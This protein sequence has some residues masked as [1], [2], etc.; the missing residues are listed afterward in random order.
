MGNVERADAVLPRVGRLLALDPL[1]LALGR[2]WHYAGVVLAC[3]ML[4][5]TVSAGMRNSFGVFVSPLVEQFG[6]SLGAVSFAYFILFVSGVPLA[7]LAGWLADTFGVRPVAIVAVVLFV[8][9]LLLTALMTELWQFYV[10][11]A[12]LTGGTGVI[13]TTLLPVTMTQWFHRRAGTAV[14]LTF[15][16]AGLG[17]FVLAVLFGWLISTLGW[18]RA[19]LILGVVT[20]VPMLAAALLLR[21]HPAQLGLSAYGQGASA[22]TGPVARRPAPP[23]GLSQVRRD[24]TIW[25]L[26]AMHFLGCVAHAVPLAHVVRLAVLKGVPDVLAAGL[27]STVSVVSIVSRFGVPILIERWSAKTILTLGYALQSLAVL[28]YLWADSTLALYLISIA[29]GLAFGAEMSSFP[30][31]NRRYYGA[32]APLNSIHAWEMVGALVGM[33]LGGWLGGVLFDWTGSYTL[34]IALAALLGLVAVPCILALP[35]QSDGPVFA[36]PEPGGR[37]LVDAHH[38]HY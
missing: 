10:F 13:F 11:Y 14:G 35:R 5:V 17:P 18:T 34:S 27:L 19:F 6:W 4:I 25:L 20:G 28:S 1:A 31:L 3:A 29:F 24:R 16:A 8:A 32:R 12:V 37:A 7:L 2:R 30:I 15:A 26:I 9:G 36:A 21:S 22:A 38:E 23:V 33:G